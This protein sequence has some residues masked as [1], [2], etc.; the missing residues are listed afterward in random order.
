MSRAALPEL[1]ST[2]PIGE[3]LPG[4]Y[5]VD[6]F[7]QRFTSGLDSVLSSILSTMDNLTA[8]LDPALAPEDFVSWLASWVSADLDPAW[9]LARRREVVHRAVD[10]HRR[11]GTAV[12]LRELLEVSLGV[13]AEVLDG[14]GVRWS[15]TPD[16]ELPG[17]PVEVVVVRVRGAGAVDRE[18]VEALVA[19]VCPVHVR[20]AVEVPAGEEP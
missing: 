7:T 20:C 12:G 19:A 10:L 4:L 9:P 3:M 15:T 11:R 6:D 18:L 16:T 5:A 14:P 13:R 17:E 1:P 2:H 8:Y